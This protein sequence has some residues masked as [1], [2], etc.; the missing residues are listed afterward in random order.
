MKLS[1]YLLKSTVSDFSQSLKPE[2]PT[3]HYQSIRGTHVAEGFEYEVYL[4]ASEPKQPKWVRFIQDHV[5][6]STIVD[7][8]NISHSMLIL[9]K[10]Q[11]IDG[12]RF[13]AI[14]GTHGYHII[15]KNYIEPNF[16][17]RT[18]LNTVDH[19]K[20]K[21]LDTRSIGVQTKQKRE[22]TNIDAG[23]GDFAFEFDTEI[24]RIVQGAC[25]DDSIGS[26]IG[27]S[28][29]LQLTT[30]ITFSSLGRLCRDVYSKYKLETY[31]EHFEF[32]DYI[33]FEKDT[34][35][36]SI[37]DQQLADAI[38][39]KQS[40]L[41]ISM[42]CPDLIEYE[43]AS[44]YKIRGFGRVGEMEA[45]N[46]TD[47]YDFIGSNSISIAQLKNSIFFVGV[48]D[49]DQER[50][51]TPEDCLYA[52]MTFEGEING[53]KYVLSNKNWYKIDSSYLSRIERELSHRVIECI[54]PRLKNWL[55]TANR[56]GDREYNEGKYNDQYRTEPEF[57]YLDKECFT[58][59]RGHGRSKIEVADLYHHQTKKLFCIK[60]LTSSSTLSHL[61]SQATVSAE[62]FREMEEYK[63]RFLEVANARWAGVTIDNCVFDELIFV[64]A[65]ATDR[66]G[67]LIELLPIF[68]KINLLKHMKILQ[69]MK[70]DVEIAQIQL[71]NGD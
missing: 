23:I 12:L 47:T 19:N 8:L 30:P 35:I 26:R 57:L 4:V 60:K 59:G 1:I 7:L 22:A 3:R 17:L 52:F 68:S 61:F 5:D 56:N 62:L 44:I 29:S 9:I 66:N 36:I 70:F 42:A 13:F 14:S 34:S 43:L 41:K 40:D 67:N 24:L 16:G 20:L 18:T 25:V 21:L 15:N 33:E 46:L 49:S 31:K 32:I 69:K 48:D 53:D 11:T 54:T 45:V 38:N 71:L 51:C 2:S 27:G 37:L 10:V 64:Y 58:F 28:D 6:Y 63:Q 50:A 39:D 55:A 65:I